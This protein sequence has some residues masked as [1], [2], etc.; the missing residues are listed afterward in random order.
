MRPDVIKDSTGYLFFWNVEA[1]VGLNGVNEPYDVLFV[2]W[3]F[4][5]LA[6]APQTTGKLKQ[7]FSA[8]GLTSNCSGREGD[9][10]IAA[11]KAYQAEVRR[12]V[13]GRVSPAKGLSYNSGDEH[14]KFIVLGLNMNLRRLHPGVYPRLDKMPHFP[15]RL[16]NK[17]AGPFDR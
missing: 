13:D 14:H 15:W 1:A 6:E 7:L 12:P 8:A 2:S 10:L 17:V 9:P 5:K 16:A 3:C 4:F 11:I